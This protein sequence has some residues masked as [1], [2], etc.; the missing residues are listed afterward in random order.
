MTNE[1]AVAEKPYQEVPAEI[2]RLTILKAPAA[3]LREWSRRYG[4]ENLNLRTH[5]L[6]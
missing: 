6:K 2:D 3:L 1:S 4:F 5:G